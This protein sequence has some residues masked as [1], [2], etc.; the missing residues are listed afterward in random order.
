MFPV[1]Y[2]NGPFVIYT[3]DFF[4]ALGL[5]AGLLLYYRELQRRNMLSLPIFWISIAAIVG[6]GIGARLSVAWQH[7]EYYA[8]FGSVPLSYFFAHSG[9]SIIG[10]ILGGYLAIYLAKRAFRYT[11]STGDCYAA[12]IPLAMAIGRVGCFLS[13]LPL[14]TPTS[15]PWGVTVSQEAARHFEVC[16]YCSGKMHPSMI[17]EII[18]HAVA[19]VLIL[20]YRRL[21]VVQGDALKLYLLAAAVFRFMVEFVRGSPEVVGGLTSAQLALIPLTLPLVFY[22]VRQLR[23]GVYRMPPPVPAP[24]PVGAVSAAQ[25][26]PPTRLL[27]ADEKALG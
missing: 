2:Q 22:F 4:T 18:F 1:L 3:H 26:G 21:I 8:S 17:Y 15:L 16:P 20:R 12:A 23:R 5:L 7:P 24:A 27:P 14:G 13:E 19:F 6:G 25:A 9:K 10:G 11:R